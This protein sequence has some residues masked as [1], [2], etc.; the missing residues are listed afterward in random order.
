MFNN[1]VK[2]N[3]LDRLKDKQEKYNEKYTDV[4]NKCTELY[5]IRKQ[6]STLISVIETYINLLANTP[7]SFKSDLEEIKLKVKEFNYAIELENDSEKFSKATG[8][9]VAG[10]V[11]TGV[12]VAAFAPTAAMAIATTFGTASTGAAISGLTGA[13]ATN[14]ALAWLGGGALAAGGGGM[15]AGNALLAL[16][17]PVGW[18]I[19][20][21]S[22]LF[23]SVFIANKNKKIAEEALQSRIEIESEIQN[24]NVILTKVEDINITTSL[25]LDNIQDNYFFANENIPY[26]YLECTNDQ[27]YVLGELVNSTKVL[28]ELLNERV[29]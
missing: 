20:G 13:A 14:A 16:A 5:E 8:V 3:A 21:A 19:G 2:N 1:E 26:D 22:L 18:A 12:G 10:G 15:A 27:K 17:G 23:G 29:N 24:L 4:I 25:S 9:S 11:A 6:S 28:S 7:K